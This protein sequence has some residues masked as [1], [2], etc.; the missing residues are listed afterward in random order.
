MFRG[1]TENCP[2]CS[3]CFRGVPLGAAMGCGVSLSTQRTVPCVPSVPCVWQPARESAKW[4]RR[5]ESDARQSEPRTLQPITGRIC[6]A[7]WPITFNFDWDKAAIR[8]DSSGD[9]RQPGVQGP[10]WCV[11]AYFFHKK[12]VSRRRQPKEN[13]YAEAA[14]TPTQ[15]TQNVEHRG[16]FSG[17]H[18]KPSPVFQPGRRRRDA[19]GGRHRHL[20]VGSGFLRAH[21][22]HWID[23]QWRIC[24]HNSN[25]RK[26]GTAMHTAPEHQRK[27]HHDYEFG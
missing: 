10:P 8:N 20:F 19:L 7:H 11:F 13:L 12:K 27:D 5:R 14:R 1:N 23:K 17:E 15:Q 18:R 4:S 2:Q 22:Y 21:L 26:P 25:S 6:F 9:G 24:Y 16:R 3:L